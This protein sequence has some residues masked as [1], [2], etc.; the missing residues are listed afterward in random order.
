M[1]SLDEVINDLEV[2]HNIVNYIKEEIVE[3]CV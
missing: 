1:M 2:D 3:D